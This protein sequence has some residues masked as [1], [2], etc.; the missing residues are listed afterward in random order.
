MKLTKVLNW[1]RQAELAWV[2]TR[3]EVSDT[4]V[5]LDDEYVDTVIMEDRIELPWLEEAPR[6]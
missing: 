5:L 4:L 3:A 2:E 1:R 6:S